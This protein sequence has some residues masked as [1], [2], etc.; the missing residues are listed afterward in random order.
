MQYKAGI[1]TKRPPLGE[2]S[3]II[4]IEMRLGNVWCLSRVVTSWK[5]Y[6][7]LFAILNVI[8]KQT[9]ETLDFSLST[10]WALAI[11]VVAKEQPGGALCCHV[12]R[13]Y[14]LDPGDLFLSIC[15]FLLL[16]EIVLQYVAQGSLKLTILWPQY[17][18]NRDHRCPGHICVSWKKGQ[19]ETS[20]WWAW[21]T[22]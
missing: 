10:A 21:E 3:F 4:Q 19:T 17:P 16:Y 22:I 9:W 15:L 2:I 5:H 11:N 20:A 18:Q 8:S 6:E 7:K 14:F 13:L 12:T 1:R